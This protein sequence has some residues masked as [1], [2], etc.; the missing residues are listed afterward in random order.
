MSELRGHRPLSGL[1][2]VS[3]GMALGEL[4]AERADARPTGT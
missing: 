4:I 2:E 1:P 3:E